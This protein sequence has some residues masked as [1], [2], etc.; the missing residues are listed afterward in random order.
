MK[1]TA[2]TLICFL[3]LSAAYAQEETKSLSHFTKIVVSPKINLVLVK[4]ETESIKL[5]C[6][7]ITP[8]KVY[9]EVHHGKLHIYLEDAKIIEKRRWSYRN[10][11]DYYKRSVYADVSVTAYVT[12]KQLNSLEKRG[13][14]EVTCQSEIIADKFKLRAYGET[15]ITIQSLKTKKLKTSLYGENNLKIMAGSADRQVYRVFGENK[16]DTRGMSSYT[17]STRIYGEGRLSLNASEEVHVTAFGE[18]NITVKGDAQITKGLVI[19]VA[20]INRQH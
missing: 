16:V 7:N 8:E 18:P 14:E 4:G 9:V 17:A 13:E 10:D 3:L 1:K 5:L 20:K 15:E 19:G 2:F 11:Y 6:N 12:F